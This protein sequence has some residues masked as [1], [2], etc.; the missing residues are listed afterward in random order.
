MT[1]LIFS[2]AII[3]SLK[4]NLD[5]AKTFLADFSIPSGKDESN[6]NKIS[7]LTGRRLE[8]S[9][10]FVFFFIREVIPPSLT[11]KKKG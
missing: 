10:R 5:I 6:P 11:F 2:E 9:E 1:K 8:V 7:R 4:K 3:S